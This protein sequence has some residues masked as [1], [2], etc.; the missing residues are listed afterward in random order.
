MKKR[1]SACFGSIRDE[2]TTYND[3]YPILGDLPL[4][5]RLFQSKASY[6]AKINLLM[7]L[8]CRLVNPDGSPIRERELRGLPGF[9]N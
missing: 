5:G 2:V 8:T 3:Q 4:V 9:R 7:F 6:S 1:W